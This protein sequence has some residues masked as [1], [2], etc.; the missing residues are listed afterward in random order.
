MFI[1]ISFFSIF[2]ASLS[3][4][5]VALSG[6]FCFRLSGHIIYPSFYLP[7]SFPF[8]P[9]LLCCFHPGSPFSWFLPL[10]H[11]RSSY[12]VY[13]DQRSGPHIRISVGPSLLHH[14]PLYYHC[15]WVCLFLCVS[16]FSAFLR[17]FPLP[18][19]TSSVCSS[20]VCQTVCHYLQLSFLIPFT[21]FALA[22]RLSCFTYASLA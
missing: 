1:P 13:S 8:L 7:D 18:L 20:F 12:L 11:L 17:D 9:A 10:C 3:F 2:S 6:H 5:S 14:L 19:A 22:S 16:P 15:Y 4:A 21:S